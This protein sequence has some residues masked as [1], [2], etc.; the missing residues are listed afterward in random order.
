[1]PHVKATQ[2]ALALR[3]GLS[4]QTAMMFALLVCLPAVSATIVASRMGTV[5]TRVVVSRLRARL[6][7]ADEEVTINHIRTFGYYLDKVTRERLHGNL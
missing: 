3:Y 1:M 7:A 6:R 4:R 5:D 2:E